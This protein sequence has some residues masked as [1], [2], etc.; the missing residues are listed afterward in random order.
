[1]KQHTHDEHI[2]GAIHANSGHK[3]VKK[4]LIS[5]GSVIILVLAAVSFIFLPAMVQSMGGELP[6]FGYFDG[7]PIKYENGSYFAQAV[8]NYSQLMQLQGYPVEQ[9]MFTIFNSAFNAAVLNTAFTHE[10]Q[11]AGYIVPASQINEAMMPYYA[12]INGNYSPKKFNDTPQAERIRVRDQAENQLLHQRYIDDLTGAAAAG[13][14]PVY[15]AKISSKEIPFIKQ[16]ALQERSFR[17]AVF[18]T[19][20]YPQSEAAAFGQAHADLFT[21]YDLSVITA[22]T[23]QEAESIHRQLAAN[24][25]V[26]EDAAASLSLK[27]YSGDDGK[28]TENYRYQLQNMLSNEADLAAVTG[29]AAGALSGVVQAGASYAVFRADGPAVQPDFSDEALLADVLAYMRIYE[30]GIIE[31]YFTAQATDFAARAAVDGFDQASAALSVRTVDIPAFPLNYADNALFATI[32]SAAVPELSGA[33][34]NAE[35]LETA[36]S[37]SGQ[38]LSQPLVLGEN[39][40]VL[41]LAAAEEADETDLNLIDG[42]Y[43]TNVEQFDYQSLQNA[44]MQDPR[45]QNDFFTVYF[46]YFTGTN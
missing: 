8:Q 38:E 12:D 45:F 14:E 29:L 18:N 39:I 30:T 27:N 10:V 7:V 44:V 11:K 23:Q 46:E 28:L 24:E 5:V 41:Q 21:R 16:A 35:F 36:F 32:P 9:S 6:A 26:F 37:L 17:M 1:M 34:T 42:N 33:Q 15:G 43:A 25:I 19:A 4:I 22:A 3:P 13:A 31:D 20:G 2:A 40:V